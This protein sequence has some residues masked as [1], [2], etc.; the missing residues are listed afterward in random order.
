M[1]RYK[2]G[3]ALAFLAF[4]LSLGTLLLAAVSAPAEVAQRG[5]LRVA[6]EGKLSPS[7][8]PRHGVAP[9]S[10]SLGGEISTTDRGTP[11]QLRRV[12]IAVNRFG[13]INSGMLPAC[14]VEQIQ[15]ATTEGAL[16]AC[17][18]SLVGRGKFSA[19]VLLP[20]QAPFPAK[21]ELYA[22]NGTF[23]GRPAILAHVYGT[24][25]APTSYTLPLQIR[26]AKG[27][28]G[29][30]LTASL[31][32]VT[33]EWG[34]VTGLA[35]TLDRTL[36]VHG[37]RRGYVSAGCPAAPGF[38][39]ASFPLARTTFAFAGGLRLAAT[40]NRSCKAR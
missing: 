38:P 26:R 18:S 4:L 8:L 40:L 12:T 36:R 19:K 25:P 37:S 5:R 31:P 23:H 15:P 30:V 34:Y 14:R 9:V 29:T 24:E 27:V 21:G 1:R 22:Y 10:V 7:A 6:F 39:G 33:S 2:P 3:A 32:E 11:P 16:E 13:Q 17:G 28:F 35:L 20:A